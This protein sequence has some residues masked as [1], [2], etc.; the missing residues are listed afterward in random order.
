MQQDNPRKPH[1]CFDFAMAAYLSEVAKN[2]FIFNDAIVT[3]VDAYHKQ[4]LI[5]NFCAAV[6][7]HTGVNGGLFADTVVVADYQ[8]A[9]LGIGFEIENLGN[10]P[11][12]AVGKEM[13]AFTDLDVSVDYDVG[14][15]D[16]PFADC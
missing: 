13:I 7:V 11:D 14:F 8:A 12:D 3:D 6:V 16:G 2:G 1:A 10:A 15:E 4:V 5:T 9:E